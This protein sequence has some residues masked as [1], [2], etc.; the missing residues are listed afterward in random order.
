MF[1][2][3]VHLLLPAIVP[4]VS[5]MVPEPAVA[6]AVPP[7]VLV[8]PFGVATTRPTGKVSVNA[9]P[10]SGTA[11][12]GGLVMVIVSEVVPFSGIPVAPNALA[13]DGGATTSILADAGPPVPPSAD[14]TVSVVSFFVR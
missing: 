8:N 2:L 9:T 7:H 13:I 11:L 14:V 3:P 5:V 4:P 12:A 6:V 1:T 10:F